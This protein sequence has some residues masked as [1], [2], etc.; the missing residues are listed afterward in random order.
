[1]REWLSSPD[2]GF[3][4]GVGVHRFTGEPAPLTV[5]AHMFTFVGYDVLAQSAREW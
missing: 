3:G 1:M 2:A 4:V 5:G